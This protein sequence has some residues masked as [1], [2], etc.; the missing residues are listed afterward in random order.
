MKKWMLLSFLLL[1][2]N[3]FTFDFKSLA[4]SYGKSLD[5]A[6]NNIE[7]IL[8]I[9]KKTILIVYVG[10][11]A[12]GELIRVYKDYTGPRNLQG[13]LYYFASN[14]NTLMISVLLKLGVDLD[15]KDDFGQTALHIAINFENIEAIKI[16]LVSGASINAKGYC[17]NSALH[18]SVVKGNI[19]ISKMLLAA[20]ADIDA[21]NI[22]GNTSLHQAVDRNDIEMVKILLAFRADYTIKNQRGLDP[23][24]CANNQLIEEIL[25]S[26]DPYNH[27]A[28]LEVVRSNSKDIVKSLGIKNLAK[29]VMFAE[30][31][32]K[33]PK[34]KRMLSL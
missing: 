9:N 2:K 32:L 10:L 1:G 31:G 30:A 23:L 24:A 11:G 15:A 27:P 7:K 3:I 18:N 8:G 17:D 5:A 13:L 34:D 6:F 12:L 4:I 28:V 29:A 22:V 25:Q 14:Q 19:E 26:K 16:L 21:K 20:N 33:R